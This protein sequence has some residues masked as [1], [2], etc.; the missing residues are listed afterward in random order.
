MEPSLKRWS[1]SP[2]DARTQIAAGFRSFLFSVEDFIL[3][4][5]VRR[6][7]CH[8]G[9][10]YHLTDVSKGAMTVA[11]AHQNRRERYAKWYELLQEELG[12]VAAARTRVFA[13]GQAVAHFLD[14][15]GFERLSGR[16]LHYGGQAAKH[17][18]Q[19][20]QGREREFARFSPT[21]SLGDIIGVAR[22][23][24]VEAELPR[25][26]IEK[27]LDRVKRGAGLTESRRK[28]IFAY[29]AKFNRCK[30]GSH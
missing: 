24:M 28:L 4:F 9:E 26:M 16:L 19:F 18:E 2:E 1:S 25:W 17:R 10:T 6:F 21:V 20:I 13:V 22:D 14:R 8:E 23:V 5:C 27:T 29:K 7:A 15:R 30:K 3:H 12:L 11:Q